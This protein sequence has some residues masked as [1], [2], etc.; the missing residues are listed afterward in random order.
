MHRDLENAFRNT[1]YRVLDTAGDFVLQVDQPSANLQLL[2]VACR[3]AG[4]ALLTAFNP[5]ARPRD[6]EANER[7]QRELVAE[8]ASGG[9]RVINAR[10][11]DPENLWPIEASVLVPGL[12]LAS[13]HRLAA[14]HGQVAFLWSDRSGTPRLV[15]TDSTR[16]PGC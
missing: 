10:N 5:G 9:F 6:L 2:L 15:E 1:R 8:L 12:P 3:E 11:E 4:A 7:A 16:R 13:A 14:Q